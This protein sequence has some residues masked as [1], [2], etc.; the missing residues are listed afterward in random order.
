[1]YCWVED[2]LPPEWQAEVRRRREQASP[3]ERWYP[4]DSRFEHWK[5]PGRQLFLIT[6]GKKFFSKPKTRGYQVALTG[7][8]FTEKDL[9][10][11]SMSLM[12]PFWMWM[13]EHYLTREKR[14]D[15]KM[16]YEWRN[17][18]PIP[19]YWRGKGTIRGG[20]TRQSQ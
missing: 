9:G 2:K 11:A 18:V 16:W 5:E 4:P 1:M 6:G 13:L 14:P 7:R 19:P 20:L 15:K 8:R 10:F 17:D 12:R 3:E